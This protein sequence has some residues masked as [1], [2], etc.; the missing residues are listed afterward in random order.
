[1]HIG[2]CKLTLRIPENQSLKG[3]RRVLHSLCQRVR[4]KFGVSIAEVDSNEAWQIAT[5]GMVCVSGSA[6]HADEMLNSAIAYIESS[7]QDVEL[8]DVE[9][10][11]ITGF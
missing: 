1:M 2:V 7:R 4:S 9:Q 6:R 10:E 5:L 8:V 11:T 3:K